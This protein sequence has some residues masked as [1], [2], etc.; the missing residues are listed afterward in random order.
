[1]TSR[2][3]K[4]HA[5]LITDLEKATKTLACAHCGARFTRLCNLLHHAARCTN[6]QT[7]I[8]CP[9]EKIWH[10]S[11]R[12]K[13]PFIQGVNMEKPLVIG[14]RPR[15]S[16]GESTSII[17]CEGM[18][19]S[20]LSPGIQ[21]TGITTRAKQYTKSTAVISMD[22]HNATGQS[23]F[24][25]GRKGRMQHEKMCIKERYEE[26]KQMSKWDTTWLCGAFRV[27]N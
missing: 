21:W 16:G 9:G 12:T 13:G 2:I 8:V 15:P 6:R 25:T 17:N 23:M 14:Q 18:G 7:K 27:C 22:V 4:E 5:F 19:G 11:P 26:M 20:G 3:H 1:M 10:Q 24:Y